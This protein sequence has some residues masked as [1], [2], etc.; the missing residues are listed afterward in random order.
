MEQ[1][2]KEYIPVLQKAKKYCAAEERCKHDLMQKMDTW[3]VPQSIRQQIIRILEAENY[4]SELRYAELYV[5]S[6]INQNKWGLLK[7]ESELQRKNLPPEIIQQAVGTI[8][9]EQYL[10]NLQTLIQSKSRELSQHDPET[11]KRRIASF[12]LSRG[13]EP[14]LIENWVV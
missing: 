5:R 2:P 9:R 1:I 10:Q 13:Y 11:R 6:K 7:I 3:N 8:D 14:E 4:L 12:L